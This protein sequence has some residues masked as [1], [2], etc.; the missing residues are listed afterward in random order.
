[1]L[2]KIFGTVDIIT[3]GLLFFVD[4]PFP[5]IANACMLLLLVK[6]LISIFP[7]PFLY[8][9]CLVMSFVDILS[10]ILI[11][12]SALPLGIKAIIIPIMLIKSVPSILTSLLE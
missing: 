12:F 8:I 2:E 4:S 1:M 9:P 6:G 5:F 7:I 10:A 11:A 3:A